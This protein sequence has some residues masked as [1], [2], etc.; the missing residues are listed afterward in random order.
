V[1]SP[2]DRDALLQIVGTAGLLLAPED[3]APYETAARY[4]G[5]R[6]AAV[7]RPAD[8]AEVSAVICHCVRR[9]LPFTPQSGN[10]SLVL[11]S[12]PDG[13]GSQIVLSLER[14]RAP[15]RIDAAD[16]IVTV[17]A[18]VRLS[19]L[20][21]ALEPHGLFL[22]IDVSSDPMIGGMVATN[23]GGARFM[24]Y[25]DMRRQV[26]GLEVVL[27][28]EAGT[29]LKLSNGLRKDNAHLDLRQL[30]V[31]SCGAFG[32]ITAATL[33]VQP[34]PRQSAVALLIPRDDDAVLELLSA[35]ETEAG[36][37]LTA[38]EGMSGAAMRRALRHVT[39]LRNP[40][41]GEGLPDYAIL[42]ELTSSS[43][44]RANEPSLDGILEAIVSQLAA[45]EFS[46]LADARF[47]AP[48]RLWALRH[49]LS[50]GLRAGGPVMG[51]DL[52]FRRSDV[53]PFRR[54]ATAR[55]AA[56]FP[57]YE[58]C[59]FGHIADGGV[60]FNLSRR[61]TGKSDPAPAGAAAIV[62]AAVDTARLDALHA[63]VL[64]LAVE[65]FGASFSGE[66][67]IGRA[68]QAA[69][70][71]FTPPAIQ[72]YSAAIAAVFARMPA[73]AVRFGPRPS[74]ASAHSVY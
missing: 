61:M 43:V 15:P 60:H 9:A 24:R 2:Q 68:N 58:V 13:S 33:E 19:A 32:V 69:Y 38:F 36:E 7:V 8:T 35:F 6:A 29:V 73:P 37:Y 11:G 44:P 47:G 10:T 67:G 56:R 41:A 16:R 12:T 4:G 65:D 27:P 74:A 59:D 57:E 53:M 39:S 54:I 26:L 46:P 63:E 31:G 28:D 17:A 23:T 66:H 34:R 62:T 52:S 64:Q 45:R 51:F 71:R 18:G 5:G 3:R 25:G 22:P 55:L 21:G 70:D 49:S 14:L 40:F 72:Q 42:L 50:E 30:F 20:N 48:E 1:I